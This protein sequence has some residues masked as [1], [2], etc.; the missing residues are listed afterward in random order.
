MNFKINIYVLLLAFIYIVDGLVIPSLP[1][2]KTPV[3]KTAASCLCIIGICGEPAF[4][5]SGGGKDYANKVLRDSDESWV[6]RKEIG[7]DFT[8]CDAQQVKFTNSIL[9]GSRFYKSNLKESDFTGADLST[10]S[11]EDTSLDGA[12]FFDAVLEGAYL[13]ESIKDA[14]NLENVDFTDAQMPK[15]TKKALCARTDIKG[16]N[17]KTGVDTLESL[18]CF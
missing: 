1:S 2:W 5:V 18:N 4:A 14:S 9:K 16:T 11:L 12:I 15:D 10:A 13:S 6:G 3:A 7:K 17:S 8:Q